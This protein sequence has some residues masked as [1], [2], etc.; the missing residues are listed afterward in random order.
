MSLRPGRL[1][2]IAIVA[3]WAVLMSINVSR[4]YA[5]RDVAELFDVDTAAATDAGMSQRGVYYR[6]SRIGVSGQGGVVRSGASLS[7]SLMPRPISTAPSIRLI[8]RAAA[9]RRPRT[10]LICST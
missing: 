1:V 3:A 9:C 10:A 6:G 7:H 8:Q 2:S 5:R 4:S